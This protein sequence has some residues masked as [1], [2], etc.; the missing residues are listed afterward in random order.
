[1]TLLL[2]VLLILIL[3]GGIPAYGYRDTWGPAPANLLGLLLFVILILV[4]LRLCGV[5]V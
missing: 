4:L 5:W 1:V 3:A 2:I